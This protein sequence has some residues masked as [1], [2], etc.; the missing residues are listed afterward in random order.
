MYTSTWYRWYVSEILW[1]SLSYFLSI[2]LNYLNTSYGVTSTVRGRPLASRD[3]PQCFGELLAKIVRSKAKRCLP[4]LKAFSF[5]LCAFLLISVNVLIRSASA[6]SKSTELEWYS[7]EG[8]LLLLRGASSV[9]AR[10]TRPGWS[11]NAKTPIFLIKQSLQQ[12]SR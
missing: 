8:L 2:I 7:C 9:N 3:A 4:P 12:P 11:F 10:L 5:T 1:I 6:E